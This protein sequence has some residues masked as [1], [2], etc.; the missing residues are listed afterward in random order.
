MERIEYRL[1]ILI[2][3][4]RYCIW[5]SQKAVNYIE[6][7]INLFSQ[8]F[9]SLLPSSSRPIF[10]KEIDLQ[11]ILIKMSL[12]TGYYNKYLSWWRVRDQNVEKYEIK[13]FNIPA[14]LTY[15]IWLHPI[16]STVIYVFVFFG[17]CTISIKKKKKWINTSF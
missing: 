4:A 2:A 6:T 9:D 7:F 14:W 12:R 8:C 3:I 17:K 10:V 13:F 1:H 16:N 5:R 11:F 15:F